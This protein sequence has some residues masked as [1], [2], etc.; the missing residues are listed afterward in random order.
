MRKRPQFDL[1]K[2]LLGALKLEGDEDLR[3]E[4]ERRLKLLE[5]KPVSFSGIGSDPVWVQIPT[6]PLLLASR[7]LTLH[8]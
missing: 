4:I 7:Y 5:P 3:S 6:G 1:R 2:L 8:L